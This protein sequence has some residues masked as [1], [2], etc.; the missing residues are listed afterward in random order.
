M[1]T[2]K[3]ESILEEFDQ[4]VCRIVTLGKA[5]DLKMKS[6]F[7]ADDYMKGVLMSSMADLILFNASNELYKTVFADVNASG[8]MMTKRKEPGTSDIQVAVQKWILDTINATEQTN[9]TITSGFMLNPTK[10]LGYFYGA[11]KDLNYTFFDHD[12]SLC[13]HKNCQHR[14]VYVTVKTDDSEQV[15]RVKS[16]SNLLEVLRENKTPMQAD[17]SG[18]GTCGKCKVKVISKQ[19]LLSEEE[20]NFLT[21]EEIANRLVLACYQQVTEDMVLEIKGQTADILTEFEF[22]VLKERKYEI[23]EIDG[24]SKSPENNESGTDLIHHET[25]KQYQYSLPALRQLSNLVTEK[26]FFALVKN[27]NQTVE[28]NR[29]S[30]LFTVLGLTSEQ[31][32]LRLLS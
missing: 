26:S 20:E 22:P 8:M 18:N 12:C 23:T 13:D 16:G 4:F 2:Q 5:V 25:G 7:D 27:G 32:R 14:K 19:P 17:C 6:Y 29:I 11:G 31:Q 1:T 10:S 9:I 30:L 28:Y 21:K 24:L 15:M 3:D